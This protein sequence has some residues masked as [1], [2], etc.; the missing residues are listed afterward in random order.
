MIII[1]LSELGDL[2][3]SPCYLF[4]RKM[5]GSNK[6]LFFFGKCVNVMGR[7]DILFEFK[8]RDKV[9]SPRVLLLF[10]EC[11]EL[12]EMIAKSIGCGF[13]NDPTTF[14]NSLEKSQKRSF[15]IRPPGKFR[16]VK[17]IYRI[18][19]TKCPG[20]CSTNIKR[21]VICRINKL[22]PGIIFKLIGKF[23]GPRLLHTIKKYFDPIK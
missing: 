15:L 21:C 19:M 4:F 6:L 11:P 22:T 10:H 8:P 2:P 7:H 18:S 13:N 16:T 1:A 14:R 3:S 23:P 9:R 17:V 12:I 20:S 5:I